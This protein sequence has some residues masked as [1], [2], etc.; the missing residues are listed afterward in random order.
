MH[1]PS[2]ISTWRRLALSS[3]LIPATSTRHTDH[4][5]RRSTPCPSCCVCSGRARPMPVRIISHCLVSPVRRSTITSTTITVRPFAS[6]SSQWDTEHWHRALAHF[7]PNLIQGAKKDCL[8]H[9]FICSLQERLHARGALFIHGC[10]VD[11][12]LGVCASFGVLE[13]ALALLSCFCAVAAA[14]VEKC[15]CR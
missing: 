13:G 15:G 3:M 1:M 5:P 11:F 9:L 4:K 7:P 10:R 12:K 6:L 2:L 14:H 8:T